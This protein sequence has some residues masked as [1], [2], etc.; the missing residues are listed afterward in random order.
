[1]LCIYRENGKRRSLERSEEEEGGEREYGEE[2]EVFRW[3]MSICSLTS[4]NMYTLALN[5]SNR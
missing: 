1:M 2:V 3:S 5:I 4:I